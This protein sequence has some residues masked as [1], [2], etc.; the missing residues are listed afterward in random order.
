MAETGL[1]QMAQSRAPKFGHFIVEFATPGIGH[2]LKSAGFDFA[3]LDLEHSGFHF[4]T[5]KSAI[6]YFEAAA[7]PAIVRVP[8]KA[9]HHIARAMDM[10]VEG[11]MVPM[12]GSADEAR[13]VVAAMK[14]PPS[15]AR[16]VALQIAHDRYRPGS[17]RDKFAAANEKT[18]LF[19][20]IETADGVN[21]VEAI[22]AID[23]VD[24]LW[25]GHFDLSVSLGIPGEFDHKEFISATDKI[26][27][28]AKKHNKSL[29]HLVPSV[30]R[31]IE[32]SR[33]GFNF[34][35]YSGDVWVLHDALANAVQ[36]LRAGCATGV[37]A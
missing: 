33:Q 27:T 6:R 31:G 2:I 16:G 24:C 13:R 20:L 21:D 26:I 17:V 25:I 32:L 29:G 34:I 10:G 35:C 7:I 37:S 19:C 15:G 12:V 4:E 3:F 14:Y 30:E 18:T 23:E 28:A 22:A 1:K 8:S 11:L 9:T 36:R 5:V